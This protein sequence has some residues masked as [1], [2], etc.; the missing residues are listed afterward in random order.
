MDELEGAFDSW[1]MA[2]WFIQPNSSLN[3]LRPLELLG[4]QDADVLEA[5]RVDRFVAMG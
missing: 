4:K 2:V 5:A 3:E 1:E